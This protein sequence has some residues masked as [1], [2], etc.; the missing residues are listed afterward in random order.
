M[1]DAAFVKICGEDIKRE[2]FLKIAKENSIKKADQIIDE[3]KAIVRNW[4]YYSR[5]TGVGDQ[6]LQSIA[7]TL[8]VS[9]FD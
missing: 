8:M 4:T 7:N 3:L 2:D 9:K 1:V 6:H 5:Q